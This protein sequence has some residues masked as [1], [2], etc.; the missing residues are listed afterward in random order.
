M[1]AIAVENLGEKPRLM[2]LPDPKPGPG[3]VLVAIDTAAINPM[4]W[5]AA[6]GAFRGMMER[7]SARAPSSTRSP[8]PCRT[9]RRRTSCSTTW[10]AS[11]ARGASGIWSEG[12]HPSPSESGSG[13]SDVRKSRASNASPAVKAPGVSTSPVTTR[14]AASTTRGALIA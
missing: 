9:R 13:L 8:P 5:K 12:R 11:A 10:R 6:Q 1:K 3:E 4:D 7:S 14:R 2:E